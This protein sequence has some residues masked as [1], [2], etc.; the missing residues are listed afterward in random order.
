MLERSNKF[1]NNFVL[2][3]ICKSGNLKLAKWLE[4]YYKNYENNN[5]DYN[6]CMCS[7]CKNG[8]IQVVEWLI[9]F[10][11]VTS[12]SKAYFLACKN[13]HLIIAEWF[14]D[15]FNLNV[16]KLNCSLD[17][18]DIIRGTCTGGYL[19]LTKQT[20]A[21][22]SKYYNENFVG[23]NNPMTERLYTLTLL[24]ASRYGHLEI[25]EWVLSQNFGGFDIENGLRYAFISSQFKI[26]EFLTSKF[27]IENEQLFRVF[28]FVCDYCYGYDHKNDCKYKYKYQKITRW[29]I[30]KFIVTSKFKFLY[31][32]Y[33]Y[34]KE[35]D[36]VEI[37]KFLESFIKKI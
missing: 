6:M 23:N 16:A 24:Y 20:I 34:A 8:H 36:C 11:N 28:K 13:K 31:K 7:A 25:V 19:E 26:V 35:N 3:G 29:F 27:T 21:N 1:V 30:T 15:R 4:Q 17:Y 18:E 10:C 9:Y 32:M 22:A 12:I 37:V 5:S 33:E 14:I 2:K